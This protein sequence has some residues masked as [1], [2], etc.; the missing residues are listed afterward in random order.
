ME[1]AQQL[2]A[3]T[4]EDTGI[5]V[6]RKALW[7]PCEIE[8]RTPREMGDWLDDQMKLRDRVGKIRRI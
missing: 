8:P 5:D 3:C 6:E 1:I 7:A 4:A 2:E